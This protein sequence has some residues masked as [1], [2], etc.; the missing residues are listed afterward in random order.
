LSEAFMGY[1][2][3]IFADTLVLAGQIKVAKQWGISSTTRATSYRVPLCGF[4]W[5]RLF[6]QMDNLAKAPGW[7]AL[8]SATNTSA[9][10]KH[11]VH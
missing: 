5:A 9:L 11:L 2:I 4:S 7:S 6:I 1:S 10:K 8:T 3:K